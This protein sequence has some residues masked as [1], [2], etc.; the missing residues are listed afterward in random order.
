[1]F[2]GSILWW[3]AG[4]WLILN[5]AVVDIDY[6]IRCTVFTGLVSTFLSYDCG[7]CA[8][9]NDKDSIGG[10]GYARQSTCI[11]TCVGNNWLLCYGGVRVRVCVVHKLIR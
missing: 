5:T 4:R 8:G 9:R 10:G 7:V 11:N 3:A 1:M 6:D 2:L